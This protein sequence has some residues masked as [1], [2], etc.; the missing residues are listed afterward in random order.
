[1]HERPRRLMLRAAHP[2]RHP[3]ASVAPTSYR[4]IVCLLEGD[5]LSN[6]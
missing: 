5:I 6:N 1:M 2:G 3:L 4:P